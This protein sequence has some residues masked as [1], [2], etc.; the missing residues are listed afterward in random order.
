MT[1]VPVPSDYVVGPDDELS[2]Q[3]YGSQNRTLRLIVGRD[4]R[5]SFPELGPISVAGQRFNDVR[6]SIE[7]RVE[8]QLIGVRASVSMGDTRSIRV[9]VLGEA[10]RPGTYTISSLATMTSALYAAGG[11]KPIGSMRQIQLKRRGTLVRTLDLYDLLIRGDTTD[12]NKLEQGDVIFVPPVG[13]TVSAAGELHR[14]AIYEIK[15]ESSV[16]DLVALAGGL[17]P[18]ADSGQSDVGPRG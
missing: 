12:D 1:N 9:F 8:R 15:N 3:L 7:S 4:G 18:Q 13:S 2:V 14:P 16:A 10:R 6:A 17:T 5:V 11:I